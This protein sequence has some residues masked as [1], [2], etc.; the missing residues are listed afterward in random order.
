M[1]LNRLSILGNPNIGIYIF[2]ND[3]IALVPPGLTS[4]EKE[5]IT[6]TLKVDVIETK[7]AGTIIIGALVAGNNN[8]IILP[9]N[10][11]D[12]EYFNLKNA[13]NKYGIEV[14][15]S[16]SKNTALGNIILANDK[17][18]ISGG[19]LEKSEINALREVLGV[20]IIE[21]NIMGLPIP[22]SLAVVTNTGGVVHPDISDEELSFLENTFGVPFERASVNSGVPFIKTGLVANKYGALVG[23]LTTGPE[24][25]RIQRGL[26]I[27]E[28]V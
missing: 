4:S 19:V 28:G 27:G 16:S 20:D 14:Y 2:A 15:V 13:L 5:V 26:G 9:R 10:V 24:I 17:K 1:L 21:K 7:I 8:G 3:K 18:C 12:E 22:G 11:L 25:M 6:E 23:E